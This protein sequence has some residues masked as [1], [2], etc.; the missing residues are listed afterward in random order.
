MPY[1]TQCGNQVSDAARFCGKCGAPQ[2]GA[3]SVPRSSEFL[4]SM[5]SRTASVLCYIP[6]F[7]W[8]PAII[9]LASQRFREDRNVRFH[10][11]QGL[12]L[13]VAWLIVDQVIH[14]WFG[15]WHG[16]AAPA[17]ILQ[18]GILVAW[19]VML[20]KTS[21]SEFFS[22]PIFGELAEKSVS[23]QK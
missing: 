22:L 7:G 9:V 13:F 15:H 21:R 11:F 6:F 14:P 23:E 8:I 17:K 2:A 19:I 18:L 20:V 3:A 10:A 5:S 1:C 16:G 4:Q 12:Y